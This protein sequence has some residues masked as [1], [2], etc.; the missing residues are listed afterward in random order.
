MVLIYGGSTLYNFNV[1]TN[2]LEP[3]N[4]DNII[5]QKY[6]K[7]AQKLHTLKEKLQIIIVSTL[8]IFSQLTPNIAYAS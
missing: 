7:K 4:L 2:C 5:Q 6:N 1:M 8:K 3:E